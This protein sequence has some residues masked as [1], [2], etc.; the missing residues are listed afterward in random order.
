MQ[1]LML[2][3]SLEPGLQGSCCSS[4]SAG[5]HST[6]AAG[7][8]QGSAKA[9]ANCTAPARCTRLCAHTLA[10]L[11]HLALSC[12]KGLCTPAPWPGLQ[13]GAEAEEG[14]RGM[15]KHLVGMGLEDLPVEAPRIVVP[16]PED[17]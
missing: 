12:S 17:D 4:S 5:Q 2:E 14:V 10:P 3:C 1:H 16:P 11:P 13:P 6:T 15:R 8:Q 9:V 7:H